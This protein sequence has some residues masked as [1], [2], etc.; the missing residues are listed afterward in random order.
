MCS[1]FSSIHVFDRTEHN[2]SATHSNSTIIICSPYSMH[3]HSLTRSLTHSLSHRMHG[4]GPMHS[5]RVNACKNMKDT[6]RE[7]FSISIGSAQCRKAE[8]Q[9]CNDVFTQHFQ[10]VF[11]DRES[12][13]NNDANTIKLSK[14]C[15]A[16][17]AFS[18]RFV[19]LG[20]FQCD[21]KCEFQIGRLVLSF[22][23]W[24]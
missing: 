8:M 7:I 9:K 22:V 13:T 5:S 15:F 19:L 11:L 10:C 21:S 17:Y 6:K 20:D 16:F 23:A 18:F 2:A 3:A 14:Q 1:P 24:L 4:S 12:I